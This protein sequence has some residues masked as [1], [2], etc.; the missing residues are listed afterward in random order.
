M[1][2]EM[3]Q[4]VNLWSA[5]KSPC[6]ND[7]GDSYADKL[8]EISTQTLGGH[9]GWKSQLDPAGLEEQGRRR[10]GDRERRHDAVNWATGRTP[11]RS[12]RPRV[13]CEERR[14]GQTCVERLFD[15]RDWSQVA[16]RGGRRG[17][18]GGKKTPLIELQLLRTKRLNFDKF[19][20]FY[21]FLLYCISIKYS[22]PS[23]SANSICANATNRESRKPGSALVVRACTDF[24]FMS[25]FSKQCSITTKHSIY[26]VLGIIRNLEVI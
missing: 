17:L 14:R 12:P 1:A 16:S 8:P 18:N 20:A 19:G 21:I 23:L 15:H 10:D 25:L 5:A 26:I 7:Q 13:F 9:Y 6:Q 3:L 2:I 11:S 24:F 4:L 22:R